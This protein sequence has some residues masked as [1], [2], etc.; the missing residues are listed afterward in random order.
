MRALPV[1]R[2][3]F[4]QDHFVERQ[5]GDRFL[6]PRVL[7]FQL[8]QTTG[9]IDAH[10]TI[11]FPPAVVGDALNPETPNNLSDRD[12]LSQPDFRRPQFVNDFLR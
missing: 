6:Q 9:L 1:S 7:R 8:F 4:R 10:P 12:A 11:L 2:G 3:G 5:I